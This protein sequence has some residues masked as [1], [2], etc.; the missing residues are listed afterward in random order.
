MK[1]SYITNGVERMTK[2]VQKHL[3]KDTTE[4]LTS[5]CKDMLDEKLKESGA[6]CSQSMPK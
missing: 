5:I 3:S 2:R 1:A 6:G 4:T